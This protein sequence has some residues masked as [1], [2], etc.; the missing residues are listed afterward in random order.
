[1]HVA[2]VVH[3]AYT[4]LETN[5]INLLPNLIRTLLNLEIIAPSPMHTVTN[6]YVLFRID[7]H[8]WAFIE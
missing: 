8:K 1:M 3:V 2:C 6:L 7:L 4:E 5:L